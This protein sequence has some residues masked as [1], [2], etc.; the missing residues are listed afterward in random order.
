[1]LLHVAQDMLLMKL[2]SAAGPGSLRTF[3]G[4]SAT[5]RATTGERRILS[6]PGLSA[7]PAPQ[8]GEPEPLPS[9]GSEVATGISLIPGEDTP[10]AA[11]GGGGSSA[12]PRGPVS[13]PARAKTVP[14][15]TV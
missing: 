2:A 12:A 13:S 4:A 15:G 8:R 14:T 9:V 1:M 5:R 11:T 6:P 7:L 3:G 10:S